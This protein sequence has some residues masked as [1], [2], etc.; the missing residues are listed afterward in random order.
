MFTALAFAMLQE[1]AKPAPALDVEA[2]TAEAVAFLLDAQEA[3]VPD[4][5]VGSMP[6]KKLAKWQAGERERLTGLRAEADAASRSEWPYEGVYRVG[7]DGRIPS[8]YRVGGT[9]IV[10]LSLLAVPG[11]DEDDARRAAVQR[12]ADFVL[13]ALEHDETLSA[14]PKQAYD[15]RGWGHAYALEFLLTA[16]DRNA[17]E[18]E[19]RNATAR[20]MLPEL[21]HRLEANELEDGGWNYAGA[22]NSPFMTGSTVLTLQHA[23]EFGLELP[24]GLIARALDALEASRADNTAYVYS[25]TAERPLQMPGSSARSCCAE[26]AL[27]AGGRG[28]EERMRQAVLGFFG[29]YEDLLVRKSQQGTHKGAYNIAPYYFFFGHT[30]AAQAIA[31]LPADEAAA[32]RT[33]LL[34]LLAS[35]REEDGSWNDRI[36]PRTSSY[37]TAMVLLALYPT[38]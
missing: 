1:S 25:G 4:P 26:L 15:V 13:D 6:E 21:V 3:Y 20:A 34:R 29:G 32:H 37:S 36:F 33:E 38:S 10:C 27:H 22:G 19:E 14:G 7:P 12:S 11:F 18:G 9:S 5:P 24:A 2:V 16:L 8:G 35:T 28:E 23:V 17:I 31:A 30:Y